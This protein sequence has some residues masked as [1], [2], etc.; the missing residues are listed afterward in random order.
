MVLCDSLDAHADPIGVDPRG[1]LRRV[2]ERAGPGHSL[3]ASI[4]MRVAGEDFALWSHSGKDSFPVA[5]CDGLAQ[6]DLEGCGIELDRAEQRVTVHL[7]ELDPLQA[8]DAMIVARM[9][10]RDL[11]SAFGFDFTLMP[12]S[13][14]GQ[15]PLATRLAFAEPVP[16]REAAADRLESLKLFLAPLPISYAA[17]LLPGLDDERAVTASSDSNPYLAV[18]A[19]VIARAAVQRPTSPVADSSYRAA[20]DALEPDRGIGTDWMGTLMIHD[21][22]E[23]ARREDRMRSSEITGWDL[24]R[25]GEVG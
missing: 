11:A 15:A 5:L 13:A 3:G 22:L 23:L 8:A 19:S 9:A 7:P 10:A 24:R 21:T 2:A 20:I 16:D 25:Y 14:T 17:G 12:A 18:A 1:C 4:E 6:S